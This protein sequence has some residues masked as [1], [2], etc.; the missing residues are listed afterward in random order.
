MF[1][2][3]RGFFAAGAGASAAFIGLLFVALSF[4]DTA[5]VDSATRTWRRIIANSSFSQLVNVF[6]VSMAGLLPDPRNFALMVC[7]TGALGLAVAIRLLPQTINKEMTG[8]TTPTLLGLIATAAYLV[9]LI[10]GLGLLRNPDNQQLLWYAVWAV[11][12]LF[13][14]A[15]ARAWEV[16]GVKRHG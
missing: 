16:T 15:L 7:V 3:Y 9:E 12:V 5:Q 6:F 4:I 2:A 1:E 10:S 14:G 8:R 11:I 13:A